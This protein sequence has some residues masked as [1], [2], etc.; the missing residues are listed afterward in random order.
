MAMADGC[1]HFIA[2]PVICLMEYCRANSIQN[3]HIMSPLNNTTVWSD[4]SLA[5]I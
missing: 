5:C 3:R 1:A 2:V 4:N